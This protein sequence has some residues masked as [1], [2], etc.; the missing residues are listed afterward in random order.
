MTRSARVPGEDVDHAAFAVDRERDLGFDGPRRQVVAE[1]PGDLLVQRGV[2]GIEEPVEIARAPPRDQVDPDVEGG[3]DS[4]HNLEGEGVD[5]PSLD[6]RDRRRGDAGR[7]SEVGLPPTAAYSNG[8]HGGA[9]AL[10][11]HTCSVPMGTYAGLTE[12]LSVRV[13]RR[14]AWRITDS[15]DGDSAVI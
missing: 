4:S 10:I 1:H 6:A 3:R 2:P 5:V 14:S 13:E 7:L 9:E 11:V 8:P 15:L 12:D